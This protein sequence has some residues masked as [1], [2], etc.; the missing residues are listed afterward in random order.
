[1]TKINIAFFIE[2][3]EL[4]MFSKKVLFSEKIIKNCFLGEEGVV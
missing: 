4:N 3:N 1:M 2:D